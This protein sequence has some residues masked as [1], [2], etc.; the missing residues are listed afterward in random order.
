MLTLSGKIQ[1][2]GCNTVGKADNVFTSGRVVVI[3]NRI[4]AEAFAEDISIRTGSAFQVI[5]TCTAD[6]SIVT[7]ITI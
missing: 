3:I 5:I 2:I 1:H 6:Q 7:V 4:L